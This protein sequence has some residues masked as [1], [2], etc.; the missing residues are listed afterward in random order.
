[1]LFCNAQVLHTCSEE[2][3]LKAKNWLKEQK[4]RYKE[5]LVATYDWRACTEYHYYIYVR[6]AHKD[7]VHRSFREEL[8]LFV[9]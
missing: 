1:M 5:K 7:Q 2:S 6:R 9:Y 4:I 3:F 8:G